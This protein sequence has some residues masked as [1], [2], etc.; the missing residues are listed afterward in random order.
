LLLLAIIIIL[1]PARWEGPVLYDF[2]PA[3]RLSLVDL[4][5]MIPLI[6]SV[7]WIQNGVWKRRIYLFNKVTIYP[8]SAVLIVFAMG[9]GL[10]MLLAS[11][12]FSF[13]YWWAVGGLTFIIM[14]VNVVLISGH[15]QK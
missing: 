10:G 11:A 14:L 5:A 6:I 2:N 7:T 13:H 3:P 8:G 12:F 9:L 1:I 4:I 15:S